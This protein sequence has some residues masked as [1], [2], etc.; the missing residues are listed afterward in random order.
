M[1]GLLTEGGADLPQEAGRVGR[2]E[3]S[4]VGGTKE[5]EMKGQWKGWTNFSWF[6]VL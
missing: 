4:E 6:T 5:K 2:R 1:R 3:H